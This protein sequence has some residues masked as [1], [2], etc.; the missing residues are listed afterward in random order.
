[1]PDEDVTISATFEAPITINCKN[2]GS[3]SATVGENTNATRAQSGE[4][5]TLSATPDEGYTVTKVHVYNGN[6]TYNVIDNGD[7]TFSFTMPASAVTVE[8]EFS[9][10]IGALTISYFGDRTTATIDAHPTI[11]SPSPTTLMLTK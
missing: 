8:V 10:T 3:V 1:M 2:G 5:V 4:T 11:R 7:G 6:N 9:K